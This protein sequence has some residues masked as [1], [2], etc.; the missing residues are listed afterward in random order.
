MPYRQ[1]AYMPDRRSTRIEQ[2]FHIVLRG[3]DA[4]RVSYEENASTLTVNCH[5]CR[6]LS[7]NNVL[8]GDTVSLEVAH[9]DDGR[10]RPSARAKVVSVK[11]VG[12]ESFFDVAVEL[13]TPR[14]LWPIASPPED[15]QPVEAPMVVET[16]TRMPAANTHLHIVPRPDATSATAFEKAA[17]ESVRSECAVKDASALPPLLVQLAANFPSMIEDPKILKPTASSPSP[18][19]ANASLNSESLAALRAELEDQ[20]ANILEDLAAAFSEE[21]ARRTRDLIEG[22]LSSLRAN[23]SSARAQD[24]A[25]EFVAD[26]PDCA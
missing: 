17:S 12:T 6:Y 22:R 9:A 13:E 1:L 26:R 5:G 11:R 8:R 15:W 19:A 18:A 7:R 21:F 14:N 25:V 2:S 24:A 16:P 20:G 4:Y 23:C 10:V 3:L